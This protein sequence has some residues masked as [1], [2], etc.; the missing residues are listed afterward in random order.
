LVLLDQNKLEEAVAAFRRAIALQPDFAG[1][2]LNFG[3]ALK[4]QNKLDEAV[5]AYRQT[6]ALQPNYSA[7][8]HNLG[9]VLLDQNKLEEAVAAFRR[10]IALQPDFAGDYWNLGRALYRQNKLDEAVGAYR[11]AIA[12]QPNYS[13]AYHNLGL[14]LLAQSKLEEADAAFRRAIALHP[15]DLGQSYYCL[16]NALRGQRKLDEAVAAYRKAID[17]SP[18]HAEAHC[19]LGHTLREQ[20][21]IADALASFRRGHQMGSQRKD[22]QYPSARWIK[23]TERLA[24]LEKKM[25]AILNGKEV[26][27]SA[28]EQL[29][30]ALFCI[31]Y[32]HFYCAAVRFCGEAFAS[33]PKLADDLQRQRRS[34]AAC[35]AILAATGQGNDAAKL[36]D[37]ERTHLRQQAIEWLQADHDLHK[38][39]AASDKPA[40]RTF[41]ANT[42]NHWQADPALAS[43]RDPAALAKLPEAEQKRWRQLWDDVAALLKQAGEPA[44]K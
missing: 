24:E 43:V 20:G 22:W 19:N 5:G 35:Y 44:K 4:R 30:F 2:Y 39:L 42:L 7:A 17:L 15:P 41:V 34:K 10:A 29:N 8:Y 40:D 31:N 38:K 28:Q 37:N 16:G 12:L 25:P 18:D 27:K 3:R 36:D 14:V 33:E 13:A 6:I 11:Q 21:N 23:E 1:A 32:K 9:L 26:L